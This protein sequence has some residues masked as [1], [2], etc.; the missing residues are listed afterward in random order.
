MGRKR[1]QGPEQGHI[2]NEETRERTKTEMWD[3]TRKTRGRT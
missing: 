2:A 3:V 1:K